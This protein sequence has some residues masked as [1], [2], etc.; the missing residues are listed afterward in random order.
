MSGFVDHTPEINQ[1]LEQAMFVGLLAVAQE[2]VGMV[3]EKM[4]TGYKHKVYDTG[5]LARSIT[6]DIDPDNNE[7]TIG[8]NVEY[9]HYVHDGHAGHAV[10]FPKLGRQWRVP[11]HAGRIHPRQTVH[12]GHVRRFR[13]RG[14]PCGRYGGR[15]QAKHGL[16][17]ATS[18]HGKSTAVRCFAYKRKGKSTA[19]PQTIKGAKA[20][21]PEAKEIES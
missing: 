5:N 19:Y 21:R 10:F 4:V 8:T 17:A 9:A 18:A 16:I 14:T 11:R 20:P 3:R 1:K 15:N 6:A 12:D 13:K 7:V 2:S